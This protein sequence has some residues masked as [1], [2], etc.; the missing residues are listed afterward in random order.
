MKSKENCNET[1]NKVT[2][3]SQNFRQMTRSNLW[4]TSL[5]MVASQ[6][7]ETVAVCA[8]PTKFWLLLLPGQRPDV[9]SRLKADFDCSV[10][11]N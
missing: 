8:R 9:M 6:E 10:W 5:S 7:D 4:T 1:K 2:F 3:I 11:E